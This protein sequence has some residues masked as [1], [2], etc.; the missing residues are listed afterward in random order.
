MIT[1]MRGSIKE[2]IP[3]TEGQFGLLTSVVLVV[4]GIGS[5]FAGYFADRFNRSR[6]I[7]GTVLLWSIVTWLTAY[8]RTYEQLLALRALLALSQV[9]CVPATVALIVDYHRGSTRSLASGLLLSGAMTGAGLSGLGGW[10][11]EGPG[12]AYAFKAFGLIGMGYSL[13]LLFLLRDPPVPE[14]AATTEATAAAPAGLGD[15]LRSLFSNRGYL[16]MLV[17]N[18]VL[19]VV[20]WSVVGWMPTYIKE[21]YNVTQGTAG[22]STTVYSNAA[23]L[24]GLVIGGTWADRWS[25]TDDR[26]RFF[27]PM[28]G[29]CLAAPAVLLLTNA[30]SL[31]LALTG[32]ALYGLFR[33]FSDANMMPML[34]LLV[35]PRYRATSW[36]VGSFF[37]TI[38]GGVGIYAGGLLRDAH[39]DISRI[40]QFAAGNLLV[41]AFLLY[42]VHR[43][44]HPA[45]T[46]PAPGPAVNR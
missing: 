14:V 3:M 13:V 41:S 29:L 34:C 28:I 43:R 12:W 36:G 37:S 38:V 46:K 5:P 8:V 44:L 42:L 30:P 35:D 24:I 40:F 19:G 20:G 17:Y 27:V 25:R 2:A 1:T 21:H 4:Y 23:A 39:I 31:N 15:A 26:A 10:L 18:C 9:A 22:M 45:A 16:L 33:Y 6:V 32:L 7:F 11:A